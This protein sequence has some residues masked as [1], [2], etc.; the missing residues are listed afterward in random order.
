[1]IPYPDQVS[2]PKSL[3]NN[4]FKKYFDLFKFNLNNHTI[5]IIL[6]EPKPEKVFPVFI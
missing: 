3:K 2:Y 1:M 4:E 6:N 5:Q